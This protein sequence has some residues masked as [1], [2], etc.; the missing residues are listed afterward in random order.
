MKV[1]PWTIVGLLFLPV[2]L[3][4]TKEKILANH[5]MNLKI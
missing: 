4:G 3:L 2:L 5:F 1:F